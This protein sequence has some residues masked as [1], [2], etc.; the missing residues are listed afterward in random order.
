MMYLALKL[1]VGASVGAVVGFVVSRAKGCSPAACN[2]RA[3]TVYSIAAGAFFG[4][5]VAWVI[6]GR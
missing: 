5:V 6:A 3:N 1:I 2:V 4:A